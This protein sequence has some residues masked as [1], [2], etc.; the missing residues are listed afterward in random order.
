VIVA[1]VLWAARALRGKDHLVKGQPLSQVRRLRTCALRGGVQ[2]SCLALPIRL[3]IGWRAYK[4]FLTSSLL[5]A[6]HCY[7]FGGLYG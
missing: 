7:L 4:T 1:S 2:L 5:V 6:R 3:R